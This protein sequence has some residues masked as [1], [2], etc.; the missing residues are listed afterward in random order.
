MGEPSDV[1][2]DLRWGGSTWACGGSGCG[3]GLGGCVC[4]VW[5]SGACEPGAV[6]ILCGVGERGAKMRVGWYD[7]G[8]WG[9]L[10]RVCVKPSSKG[11]WV[12]MGV[13]ASGGVVH[14]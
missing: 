14:G 7:C 1:E 11:M 12:G 6:G 3:F 2:G 4:S 10:L 8:A 13:R 9:E 5:T